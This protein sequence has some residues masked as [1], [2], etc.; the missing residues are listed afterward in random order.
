MNDV[1]WLVKYTLKRTFRRKINFLLYF[2]TPLAAILLSLFAAGGNPV[3][4]VRIGIVNEDHG[5]ITD[6]TIHFLKNIDHLS[7]KSV[8]L[9]AVDDQITSQK[10]DGV[11][12]FR[13]GFSESVQHGQPRPIEL[14]SLKGAEIT[15]FIKSYLHEYIDHLATLGRLANG[16]ND[17]FWKMYERYQH[18]PFRLAI[19]SLSDTSKQKAITYQTIGY[20]LMIMLMSA[21]NLTEIIIKEREERTYSRLLTTPIQARTYVLSNVVVNVLV[22]TVQIIVTFVAMKNIFHIYPNVP[23]WQ[24]ALVLFVFSLSAIGLALITVMLANSST[25][26]GALQPLITVPTCMLAGCFWPV[27]LMPKFLQ[28]AAYFLPQRWALDLLVKL[29]EGRS[30]GS[31]YLHVLILLAF[32]LTFFL[33]AVYKFNRSQQSGQFV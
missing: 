8:K 1:I 10:V 31:L 12:I 17:L 3:K 28:K 6:D 18:A 24:M 26:A 21:G 7:V 13:Q 29:Q 19:H 23:M 11:L 32:A 5:R 15:T 33:I 16:N 4:E 27:E 14:V 30:F 22:I 9:S 2:G 25:S 20:L